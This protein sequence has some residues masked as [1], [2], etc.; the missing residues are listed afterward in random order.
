MVQ[1]SSVGV[2][3]GVQDIREEG[4]G[5]ICAGFVVDGEGVMTDFHISGPTHKVTKRNVNIS[6]SVKQTLKKAK[7]EA[8]DASQGRCKNDFDYR[9]AVR[10]GHLRQLAA[11][12]VKRALKSKARSRSFSFGLASIDVDLELFG[13]DY[14]DKRRKAF[15][16]QEENFHI[17]DNIVGAGWD[18]MKG[19][20]C[21]NFVTKFVV[22][23]TS[24]NV[25]KA[26][27]LTAC[28]PH[29]CPKDNVRQF[30][31]GVL[32]QV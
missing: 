31:Q 28:C 6:R 30:L 8:F 27:V 16:L 14:L 19:G 23:L 26:L 1:A 24:M 32:Q 17:L 4:V 5:Y 13:L 10:C 3:I 29:P 12:E 20:N 15:S 2:S 25:L 9:K 18:I 7:K 21:F 11:N 22:S